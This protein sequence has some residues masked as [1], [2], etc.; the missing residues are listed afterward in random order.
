MVQW[1]S[2][3]KWTQCSSKGQFHLPYA[4]VAVEGM[5][6]LHYII[7][8]HSAVQCT[9]LHCT[10]LHKTALLCSELH[11]TALQSTALHCSELHCTK[12]HYS[13]LKIS[14]LYCTALLT[15]VVSKCPPSSADPQSMPLI[16]CWS[17]VTDSWLPIGPAGSLESHCTV[18]YCIEAIARPPEVKKFRSSCFRFQFARKRI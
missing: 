7:M 2:V 4:F 13:E 3:Y 15:P 1:N 5:G 6:S 14:V 10:K 18:L 9:A 17:H 12:L 8:Y 16:G 11:Y